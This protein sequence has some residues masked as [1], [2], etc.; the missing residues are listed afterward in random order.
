MILK[1]TGVAVAIAVF[2]L[3]AAAALRYA[4]SIQSISPDTARRA[5]QVMIGLILAAY[6]NLMPKDVGRWPA[7]AR[8]AAKSQSVL[9]VG[10]WMLTLAGLGYAGLWAFA[11]IPYADVAAMALVALATIVTVG[12]GGWAF[13]SCRWRQEAPVDLEG[14]V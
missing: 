4:Q 10:G 7:S 8:A 11:P 5:M 3:A 2:I 12:Y 6:A 14:R 1:R 9:R 13:V